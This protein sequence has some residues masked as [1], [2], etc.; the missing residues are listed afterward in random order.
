[1]ARTGKAEFADNTI[2]SIKLLGLEWPEFA[3][4]NIVKLIQDKKDLIV[5]TMLT[6]IKQNSDSTWQLEIVRKTVEF[7]KS[8][9]VNWPELAAIEKSVNTMLKSKM[10]Q[11]TAKTKG[12]LMKISEV[13]QLDEDL[14]NLAQLGVGPLIKI[15]NQPYSRGGGGRRASGPHISAVGKKFY[16]SGDGIGTRSPI[17]DIGVIKKDV[18]KEIRKFFKREDSAKAFALYIGGT[19]VLFA[20][21]DD[22]QLA[23]GSRISRAAYD[24]T[25]FEE[26][27][28]AHL[29][30]AYDRY[31]SKPPV[32]TARDKTEREYGDN[33]STS[34]DVTKHYQGDVFT[35][36][37]L[38]QIIANIEAVAKAV[39]KPISAKAVLHDRES[40]Q[41]H[42]QRYQNQPVPRIRDAYVMG[43]DL[44]VRL[45]RYRNSKR[46]TVDTIEEFIQ[47]AM[48]GAAKVVNF[49]GHPYK[50]ATTSYDKVEPAALL[51]GK[52]FTV[53]YAS[54]DPNDYRTVDVSYMFNRETNMLLPFKADW[55]PGNEGAYASGQTAVLDVK[56]YLR[57]EMKI[58]SVTKERVLP[59]LLKMY[60]DSP[61]TTTYRRVLSII[62][63]LRNAG[64]DWPEL[65]AIEKSAKA[66]LAVEK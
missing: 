64:E 28:K 42:M 20:T 9:G 3:S 63:A 15:L 6:N 30:A 26:E 52:P 10:L 38:A 5:R 16:S 27:Y 58:P 11:E 56:G 18:L 4:E 13:T 32:K 24:L 48:N 46:P 43:Q 37:D 2:K 57:S 23:G 44:K 17:V 53:R 60:K 66:N 19:P 65:A 50:M 8:V 21:T 54:N 40:A 41:L 36:G 39:N 47:V 51:S 7:L 45:A 35:T 1:M 12:K 31:Q 59:A 61:N 14:G 62:A 25:P 22:Y 29:A 33:W 49:A 55:K 34:Y